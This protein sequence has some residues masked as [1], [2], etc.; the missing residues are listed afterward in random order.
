MDPR[1][2][3]TVSEAPSHEGSGEVGGD[4]LK[5]GFLSVHPNG[6]SAESEL[7]SSG[8][9]DSMEADINSKREG[10]FNF[11]PQSSPKVD[12]C[13]N[14]AGSMSPG[15]DPITLN[16]CSVS[17]GD[18]PSRACQQELPLL[19]REC[20]PDDFGEQ[21]ASGERDVSGE[22]STPGQNNQADGVVSFESTLPLT[23]DNDPRVESTD[24]EGG[25][26]SVHESTTT[27]TKRVLINGD[28]GC[29][30]IRESNEH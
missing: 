19:G 14:I 24:P 13:S 1:C 3:S 7:F 6:K 5:T 22:F 2:V 28:E 20:N 26:N 21:W 27:D 25:A 10:S 4:T 30:Q 18:A 23:N 12:D 17:R 29:N 8:Y 15:V 9:A 11:S 16:A